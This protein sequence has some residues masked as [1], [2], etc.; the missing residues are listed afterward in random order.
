MEE[1]LNNFN[2]SFP[3]KV[4]KPEDFSPVESSI[5]KD[6]YRNSFLK[7]IDKVRNYFIKKMIFLIK[8]DWSKYIKKIIYR[9]LLFWNIKPSFDTKGF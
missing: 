2:F 1:D 3:S 6:Y 9:L 8:I 7:I 5:L 4:L